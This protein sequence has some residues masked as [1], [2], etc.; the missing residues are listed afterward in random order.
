[1][2]VE[3]QVCIIY[4]V[5]H[6]YLKDVPVERVSEYEERLYARLEAE[7]PEILR[8]IRETGK[9]E[10]ETEDK[11]ADLLQRFTRDFVA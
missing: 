2:D 4:A 1:M 7:K 5:T 3:K 11:L 10:K 9:F 8:E 6:D